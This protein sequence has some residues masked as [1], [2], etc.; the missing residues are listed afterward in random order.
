MDLVIDRQGTIRC[1]YDEM[2]DLA[3]LGSP[4]IRRAS[5]VEPD[6][7]GRWWA[8]MTPVGGAALGPFERRSEA[9]D[10]EHAWLE[11]HWLGRLDQ[12]PHPDRDVRT[13]PQGN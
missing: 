2:I 11:Q 6:T 9:L 12:V 7:A 3:A 8:D 4:S 13:V 5:R 1:V 10:A